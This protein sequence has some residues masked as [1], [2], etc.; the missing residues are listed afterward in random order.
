[1]IVLYLLFEKDY[2]I[3]VKQKF[4]PYITGTRPNKK[5]LKYIKFLYLVKKI[6][7]ST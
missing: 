7:S 3:F 1:M 6:K 4:K 2:T 5:I